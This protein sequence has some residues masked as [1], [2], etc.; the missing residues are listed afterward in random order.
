MSNSFVTPWT[1]AHEVPLSM[2][3]PRQDLWSGLPFPSLG[4]LP[5][6]GFEPTSPAGTVDSLP[7]NHLGS[8]TRRIDPSKKNSKG[9]SI[10]GGVKE[11]L[12]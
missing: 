4:D 2:G 9:I 12:N 10:P 11:G 7:L 6:P 5:N 3:S 1:V 8:P